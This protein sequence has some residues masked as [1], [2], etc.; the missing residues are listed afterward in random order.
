MPK[1][2]KKSPVHL[3]HRASLPSIEN[4]ILVINIS[5]AKYNRLVVITN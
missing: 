1:K 4:I 5:S 2:K 3:G